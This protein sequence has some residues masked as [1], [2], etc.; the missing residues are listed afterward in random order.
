MNLSMYGPMKPA[1]IHNCRKEICSRVG[2]VGKAGERNYEETT[3]KVG[4]S[5]LYLRAHGYRHMPKV[6]SNKYTSNT[7]SLLYVNHTLLKLGEG[8]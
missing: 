8:G 2:R 1:I 4:R 5:W 3:E 6:T 7:C